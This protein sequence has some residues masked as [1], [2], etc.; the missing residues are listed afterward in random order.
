MD[1]ALTPVQALGVVVGA[2][3]YAAAQW[4]RKRL[5]QKPP[6][7]DQA[8]AWAEGYRAGS[9]AAA[10]GNPTPNPYLGEPARPLP[11]LDVRQ[12]T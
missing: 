12:D 9:H 10:T 5:G 7:P 11:D 4:I 6:N 3:I 1:L 2:G 8:S